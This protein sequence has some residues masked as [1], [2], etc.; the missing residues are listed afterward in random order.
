MDEDYD[1]DVSDNVDVPSVG[2]GGPGLVA[3]L[4]EGLGPGWAGTWP[5][6]RPS[7]WTGLGLDLALALA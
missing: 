3:G 5:W 7:G 4:V 1:D 2:T 6:A